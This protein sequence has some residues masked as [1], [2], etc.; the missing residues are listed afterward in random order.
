MTIEYICPEC[1]RIIDNATWYCPDCNF[2]ADNMRQEEEEDEEEE[3]EEERTDYMEGRTGKQIHQEPGGTLS[4]IS[5]L[6]L[7]GLLRPLSR[8]RNVGSLL[9]V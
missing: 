4:P 7:G 6:L 9:H 1:G 3:E 2:D 5:R 8:K